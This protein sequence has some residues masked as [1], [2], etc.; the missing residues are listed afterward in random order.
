M[1]CDKKEKGKTN[2]KNSQQ[3]DESH[4]RRPRR[5]HVNI[6][7]NASIEWD[8]RSVVQRNRRNESENVCIG[9]RLDF[10]HIYGVEAFGSLSV[11]LAAKYPKNALV[12]CAMRVRVNE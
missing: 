5:T 6:K 3:A 4:G 8:F 12:V 7:A 1:E 2:W 10:I 11:R 9:D